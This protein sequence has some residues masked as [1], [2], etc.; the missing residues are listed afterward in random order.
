MNTSTTAPP[1]KLQ[2]VQGKIAEVQRAIGAMQYLSSGT[3]L[4][5]TKVCGNPGCHCA[6]DPAARHG[7]YYEWSYLK[8]GKLRH[9]TLT[10]AQAKLMRLAIANYRKA[11]KLLRAWE[12]HTQ[13][14]IE[15]NAPE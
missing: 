6:S 4:K 11:K 3:L 12:A 5:R 9:R 2:Q 14:L 8:A 13:R 1:A 7:P 10:P 15:L